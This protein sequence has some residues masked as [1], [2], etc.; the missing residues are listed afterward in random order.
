MSY[1]NTPRL[2]FGGNF[3]ADPSTVNNDVNHY[4]NETFKPAYQ[5]YGQGATNGWWNPEGTGN[6]RLIDCVVT[7]VT[8]LD[9]TTSTTDPIVGLKIMDAGT[10]VAG[11]IVD[12]DPQQQTVSMIWGMVVRLVDQNNEDLF[13][14]NFKPVPFNNIWWSKCNPPVQSS[15]GASAT[16]Q[17]IIRNVQWCLGNSK[18]R[19]LKELMKSSPNQ[20]SIKFNV[21]LHDGNMYLPGTTPPPPPTI[22]TVAPV[23]NP[24]FTIGRL[25]GTIGPSFENEPDHFVIGRQLY[26]ALVNPAYVPAPQ[27]PSQQAMY[28]PSSNVYFATA[29]V[30]ENNKQV[31]IDLGNSLQI[32]LQGEIVETRDLTLA[33]QDE[34]SGYQPLGKINYQSSGWYENQSGLAVIDLDDNQLKYAINYPLAVVCTGSHINLLNEVVQYA[35]ADSFVYRLN[36]GETAALDVYGA[37]LGKAQPGMV[38]N[39]MQQNNLINLFGQGNGIPAVGVPE[40]AL[41]LDTRA[42]TNSAGKATFMIRGG[43]PGN[44]RGFVDGQLYALWYWIEGQPVPYFNYPPVALAGINP[45]DFVSILLHDSVPSEKMIAPQWSDLKPIMKQYANLYPI[46]SKGIFDLSQQ[47]V[48]DNNAILLRMVFDL[49]MEDPNSMPATRDLSR[50]K[51][52]MILRYLDNVIN[53]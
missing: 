17:S 35:R 16:Y 36:P 7:S 43:D 21:D 45:N 5:A 20:L 31:V 10:R 30:D 9:G 15:Q 29:I 39:L 6:F 24:D 19:Y 2:T 27:T 50:D 25:V 40:A 47:S 38:I 1:L 48:I 14:G 51:R 37:R 22:H 23:L 34:N 42:V 3:Q 46:M 4:N 26:P 44:P 53:Q 52:N 8:Y 18:S 49:P 28:L 33:C 32:N 41:T 12:L 13:Q 11:K